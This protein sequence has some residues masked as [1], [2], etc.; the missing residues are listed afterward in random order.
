MCEDEKTA[1]TVTPALCR[2]F[3]GTYGTAVSKHFSGNKTSGIYYNVK[4]GLFSCK[5]TVPEIQTWSINYVLHCI[6]IVIRMHQTLTVVTWRVPSSH[7]PVFS[8]SS[9]LDAS[10][11]YV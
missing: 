9:A 2:T 4:L 11:L 7:I 5:R 10:C 8:I 3:W 1:I 6:R